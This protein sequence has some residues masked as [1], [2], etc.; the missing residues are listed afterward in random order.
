MKKLSVC[1]LSALLLFSCKSKNEEVKQID[2]FIVDATMN[3]VT[4]KQIATDAVYIFS[5]EEADKTEANGLLI[6]NLVVVDYKGD[7]LD[8]TPAV[9][10]ATDKTYA[11]AIGEWTIPDPINPDARMGIR[12][13]VE[14]AAE[15]INMA[16]LVYS[17]WELKGPEGQLIIHG[18]SIGSGQTIDVAEDA[19]IVEENGKQYLCVGD[20]KYE[21]TVL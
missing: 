15:S 6:G 13:M 19:V 12:I 7:L 16:T 14:G 2:G 5:T 3:T 1:L 11:D 18:Q 4:V 8:V 9:K 21:K 20:L 10:V 17:S